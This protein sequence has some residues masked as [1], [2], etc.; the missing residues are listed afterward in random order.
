MTLIQHSR[1]TYTKR[2][3]IE[4]RQEYFLSTDGLWEIL[5]N[6]IMQEIL[7]LGQVI[8]FVFFGVLILY[9]IPNINVSLPIPYKVFESCCK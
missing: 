2:E 4:Q 5:R 7:W 3:N 8:S 1:T 6:D 9:S